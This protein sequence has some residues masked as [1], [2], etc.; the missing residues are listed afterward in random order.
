MPQSLQYLGGCDDLPYVPLRMVGDMNQR[1]ADG[2]GQ[3]L[4]AHTAKDIE[5]RCRQY[6]NAPGGIAE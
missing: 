6:S 1:A 4:A 3:L 5:I 2:G